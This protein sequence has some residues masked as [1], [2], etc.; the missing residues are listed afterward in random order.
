M[1]THKEIS[2]NKIK[3]SNSDP[4]CLEIQYTINVTCQFRNEKMNYSVTW[5]ERFIKPFRKNKLDYYLDN[6]L[7]IY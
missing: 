3:P 2:E 5:I 6:K 1:I 7:Q 4:K